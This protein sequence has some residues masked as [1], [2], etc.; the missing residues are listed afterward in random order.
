MEGWK[1]SMEDEKLK[2]RKLNYEELLEAEAKVK[3]FYKYIE[4]DYKETKA[5]G[6]Q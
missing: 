1:E 2:V 6:G 3:D 5:K 4:T